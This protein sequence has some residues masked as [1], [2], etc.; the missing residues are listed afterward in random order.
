MVISEAI[1]KGLEKVVHEIFADKSIIPTKSE[2][3]ILSI[4]TSHSRESFSSR[5]KNIYLNAIS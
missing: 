1:R 2:K 5:M 3:A 4:K